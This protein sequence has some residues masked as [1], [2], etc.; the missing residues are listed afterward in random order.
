M[1][2]TW[3][4]NCL[5]RG[6]GWF[7][8]FTT[9]QVNHSQESKFTKSCY[10]CDPLYQSVPIREAGSSKL[11]GKLKEVQVIES[12]ESIHIP[13][14]QPLCSG[15]QQCA[16]QKVWSIRR[17]VDFCTQLIHSDCRVWKLKVKSFTWDVVQFCL[18]P[19][20]YIFLQGPTLQQLHHSYPMH[21][22][23]FHFLI[24][25]VLLKSLK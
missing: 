5:F 24:R 22:S 8:R 14:F 7:Y 21:R 16:C 25:W 1:A 17:K 19:P 20:I 3:P 9:C 6:M 4:T 2:L 18:S 10:N 15:S 13:S 23:G 12:L 11:G